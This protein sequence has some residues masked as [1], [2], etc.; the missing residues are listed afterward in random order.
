MLQDVNTTEVGED[1]KWIQLVQGDSEKVTRI[2]AHLD[3]HIKVEL[4]GS[5]TNNRCV[6]AWSPQDL[7]GIL[8]CLMAHHVV[9]SFDKA[10]KKALWT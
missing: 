10:K 3:K 8:P 5:L 1:S 2:F 9:G 7:K 4:L 6:F